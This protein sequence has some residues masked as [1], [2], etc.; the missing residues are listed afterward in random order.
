MTYQSGQGGIGRYS[1]C[2]WKRGAA[3]RV[4]YWSRRRTDSNWG[5]GQQ[6][7]KTAVHCAFCVSIS[8][9]YLLLSHTGGVISDGQG[10]KKRLIHFVLPLLR[11]SRKERERLREGRTMKVVI[12]QIVLEEYYIQNHLIWFLYHTLEG[13]FKGGLYSLT[14]S[15]TL[16]YRR[17]WC[18]EFTAQSLLLTEWL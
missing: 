1:T 12:L 17:A 18:L 8:G 13:N 6:A 16:V 10:D 7:T 4:S 15:F 2:G 11:P 14:F 9:I 5:R 3:V